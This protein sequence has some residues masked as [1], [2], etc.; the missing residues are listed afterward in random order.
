MA[1]LLSTSR[2]RNKTLTNFRLVNLVEDRKGPYSYEEPLYQELRDSFY[3]E[4]NQCGDTMTEV[5][6]VYLEAYIALL[7]TKIMDDDGRFSLSGGR[8][9]IVFYFSREQTQLQ[10]SQCW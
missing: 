3:H 5:T 7:E 8:L 4:Q 9:R 2:M 10:E 6:E 1:R